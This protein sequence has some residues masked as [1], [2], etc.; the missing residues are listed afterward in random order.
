MGEAQNEPFQLS[1]N[2]LLK[3]DFQGARVTSDGGAFDNPV[4]PTLIFIF[5]P[6]SVFL[7]S[8]LFHLRID[9]GF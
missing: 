4:W 9:R 3:V 7:C 5:G 6:P 1:F 8:L 2:S